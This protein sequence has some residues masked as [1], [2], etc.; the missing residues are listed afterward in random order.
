VKKPISHFSQNPS[1]KRVKLKLH[2]D[3]WEKPIYNSPRKTPFIPLE[4][5]IDDL[6]ASCNN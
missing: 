4:R 2:K 5:E 6:I 1:A 3:I